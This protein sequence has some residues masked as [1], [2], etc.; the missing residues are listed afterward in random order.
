MNSFIGD[1]LFVSFGLPR[2]M[3]DHARAAI[4]AAIEIQQALSTA[5][6]ARDFTL[7]TRA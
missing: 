2:P 6:F 1:G 3:P 5:G 7:P 4:A